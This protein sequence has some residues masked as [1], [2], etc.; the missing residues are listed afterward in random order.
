MEGEGE[1]RKWEWIEEENNGK[2]RNGMNEEGNGRREN[3]DDGGTK[4]GRGKEED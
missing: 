3:K 4:C 2:W 1:K